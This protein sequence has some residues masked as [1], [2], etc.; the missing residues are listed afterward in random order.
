MKRILPVLIAFV[1]PVLA[2]AETHRSIVII[3]MDSL[4]A[5][6][7]QTYGYGRET[8]PNIL[9]FSRRAT[10]FEQTYPAASW[11]R[12]SILSLLTGRYSSEL[13]TNLGGGSPLKDGHPTIATVLRSYGYTT[14]AIYNTAQLEPK[15]ANVQ[16]GF[17]QYVDYGSQQAGEYVEA[18][19]GR[20]VDKTIDFLRSARKP[21]FVFLHVLDPHHPYIPTRD[22]FGN[23]PTNKFRDSYSFATMTTKYEPDKV[24]PCYLVK[25]PATVP[26]MAELYDS[27]IRELDVQ[28]GRLLRFLDDDPRYRDALVIVTSDHG[29]E[30]G[31]HGGLY[32]GARFY[33]E[34]IRVPLIVRDPARPYSI[35]R[36]VPSVVSLV[37]LAPTILGSVGISDSDSDYSG[38]S[39]LPYFGRRGGLPRDTAIIE[40]LGCGYDAAAS[41]RKGQWKMILRITR[42]NIELYDLRADPGE[43]HDLAGSKRPAV[44]AAYRDL[45]ATFETW[46]HRVNRP[47][48]TRTGDATPPLPPELRERLKALGYVQ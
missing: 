45:Y 40:R 46:Y 4:R 5:D 6:H 13:T 33:E 2:Q 7:L 27:E 23:V 1:L 28:V 9:A 14:A 34:S 30:F 12:P 36:R 24:E 15:A 37:D 29:E 25:N 38:K 26:E 22:Y 43:K 21:A 31:E 8:S 39:L 3:L 19:V 32:H 48:A 35:G 42:P 17:D 16:G 41:V 44:R 47:L 11:T 20:G 10:V 18:F